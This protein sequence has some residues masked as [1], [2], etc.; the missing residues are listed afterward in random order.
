MKTILEKNIEILKE[1]I[2]LNTQIINHNRKVLHEVVQMPC[3]EKRTALFTNRFQQNNKLYAMNYYCI[4]LQ[5]ELSRT[6]K[7]KDGLKTFAMMS[8]S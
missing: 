3:S 6:M 5:F 1:K 2:E 8:L 4:K 7:Q